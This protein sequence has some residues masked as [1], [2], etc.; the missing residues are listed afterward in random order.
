ML[1][2]NEYSLYLFHRKAQTFHPPF[3]FPAR[4]TRVNQNR[5]ILISNVIAVAIAAGI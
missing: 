3:S 4:D 2:R 5:F 1:V